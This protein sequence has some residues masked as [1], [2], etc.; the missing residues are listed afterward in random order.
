[1]SDP[2]VGAGRR[3]KPKSLFE[4]Q[5]KED[6]DHEG[7]EAA[8]DESSPLA[9]Y[10]L[11]V[12]YGEKPVLSGIDFFVPRRSMTAIIGP[13]GAGKS[14]LI[15]AAL[16]I[17]PSLTGEVRFFDKPYSEVRHRVAYV[18]QRASVDW[19]FPATALDIVLMGLYREIGPFRFVSRAH[20][21][22]AMDSL[23]HVGMVRY[24]NRQIGQLSGGQQQ[25]VFLARA[26]VQNAELYIMDEP[27]AG[28]DAATEAAIVDVLKMLNSQG[29]T[30]VCVHHDLSS[31]P[32]YFDHVLLVNVEKI[33][34]GPVATAFTPDN[35]QAAYGGRLGTAQMEEVRV[36]LAAAARAEDGP[37]GIETD[38]DVGPVVTEDTSK[39][40]TETDP[41]A[42]ALRE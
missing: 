17:V 8:Q 37:T 32:Q 24:A 18:P 1:M 41:T 38:E 39:L 19:D 23:R 13:N 12:A 27:F 21:N 35:L 14:T 15:K 28:V 31:V 42:N 4:G 36:V 5:S 9:I 40:D 16:D 6:A 29:R 2:I 25:R 33:A 22:I 10:N 11:T 3:E 20:K 34:D 30:V 7:V 26:L